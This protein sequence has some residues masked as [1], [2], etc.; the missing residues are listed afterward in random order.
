MLNNINNCG[1]S[2]SSVVKVKNLLGATSKDIL[3]ESKAQSNEKPDSLI[4]HVGT[5]DLTNG[6]DL[7][8][9]VLQ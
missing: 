1:L 4:I 7:L 5:N 9:N 3:H 6:V 8:N 2:K